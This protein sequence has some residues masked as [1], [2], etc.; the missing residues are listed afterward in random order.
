MAPWSRT[1]RTT[2]TSTQTG[3]TTALRFELI[4]AEERALAGSYAIA[5]AVGLAFVLLVHFGPHVPPVSAE[6]GVGQFEIVPPE[7]NTGAFRNPTD[8]PVRG[9]GVTSRIRASASARSGVASIKGAFGGS[10]IVGQPTNIL[11]GIV[12]TRPGSSGTETGGKTVLAHGEGGVSSITPSRG[13][14]G[15]G[16]GTGADIGNVRSGGSVRRSSVTVEAL[17]VI[18]VD[19]LTPT[20]N[21]ASVGTFVRG[22]ESQLRFCYQEHGLRTNPALAGS[23]T[24]AVTV[25]SSGAV[26]SAGVTKRSWAGPGAAESEACILQA[27]RGW[28]LPPSVNGSGTYSLPFNFSR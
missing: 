21:V 25:G 12:V 3:F 15:V 13:G 19:P 2:P 18:A 20:G 1:S 9:S 8:I 11:G 14:I 4:D 16:G 26:S 24:I 23:V 7:T 10:A 6:L 5:C 27:I 28:R 17:P 22:H